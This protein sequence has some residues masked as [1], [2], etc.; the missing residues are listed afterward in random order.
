MEVAC[1]FCGEGQ[2]IVYCRA[3]SARLCLSCDRYVHNANALSQRHSRT[4]LCHRCYLR[5]GG[6]CC[7]SCRSCFCQSCDDNTHNPSMAASQHKRHGLEF[8]TGCPSATQLAALW[9]CND[10]SESRDVDGPLALFSSSRMIDSQWGGS[11]RSTATKSTVGPVGRES[12]MSGDQKME[13]SSGVAANISSAGPPLHVKS[14]S[15][16]VR[17]QQQQTCSE[18]EICQQLQVLQVRDLTQNS[19]PDHQAK[20]HCVDN[21]E[22]VLQMK[23]GSEQHPP[24]LVRG[25]SCQQPAHNFEGLGGDHSMGVGEAQSMK[26]EVESNDLVNQVGTDPFWRSNALTQATQTW[27]QNMQDL[28]VCGDVADPS[29]AFS[30]AEVDLFFDNYENMFSTCQD[31][32]NCSFEEISPRASSMGQGGTSSIKH[33]HMQSIPEAELFKPTNVAAST[34]NVMKFRE[35]MDGPAGPTGRSD[36]HHVME[37]AMAMNDIDGATSSQFV[38]RPALTSRSLTLSGQSGDSGEY[39]DC[40]ASPLFLSSGEPSRSPDS[41]SIAQA[42]D[43]A[44]LR[45][46]EKRKIRRFDK[47]VRYESR[48]ARAD[49]RKRV[50][51]R[52]VKAGQAYD[53]DPLATTRSF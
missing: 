43:S 36:S 3:D 9:D 53:Y 50:K 38:A 45:Y 14:T 41:V 23:Q 49:T 39:H 17:Q 20:R 2:A 28:G 12:H 25:H 47:R 7:A 1:D 27:G 37:I 52:F 19:Q 6:V 10:R 22:Q 4:L 26:M 21:S 32:S 35:D 15:A 16:V 46:K 13:S 8:F 29:Y 31:T 40:N 42:R 30:M 5:P 34:G 44:M 24:M 48:K 11:A 51:G 33:G 18:K